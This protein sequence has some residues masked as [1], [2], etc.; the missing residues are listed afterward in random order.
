MVIEW[1][2]KERKC[3]YGGN[4]RE[5]VVN[6]GK[7]WKKLLNDQTKCNTRLYSGTTL[8]HNINLYS[9]MERVLRSWDNIYRNSLEFNS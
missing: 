8:N 4:M 7:I 5:S 3:V 2:K 1:E 9:G 6:I